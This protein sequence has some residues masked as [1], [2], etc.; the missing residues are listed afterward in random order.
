M[1]RITAGGKVIHFTEA[2]KKKEMFS[3]LNHRQSDIENQRLKS[4]ITKT[5][6]SILILYPPAL[7]YQLNLSEL[8]YNFTIANR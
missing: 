3:V 7:T 2:K 6:L 8:R 1:S 5:K 4:N